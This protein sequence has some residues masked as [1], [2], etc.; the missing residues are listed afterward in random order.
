M[1]EYKNGNPHGKGV[2]TKANGERYEGMF[3]DGLFE[4]IGKYYFENSDVYEG[5]F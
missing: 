3:V 5:M 4:G 2:L 1:G